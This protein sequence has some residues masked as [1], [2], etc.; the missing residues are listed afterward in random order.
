MAAPPA[1]PDVA[2]RAAGGPWEALKV[3]DFALLWTGSLGS[4][5]AMQ[6]QMLASGYLAYELTGSKFLL[7]LAGAAGALPILLFAPFGGVVA[8]RVDKR[9]LLLGTQSAL[10]AISF[11]TALLIA[12]GRIEFWH[13]ILGGFLS[14]IVFAF[15]M[16]ARQVLVSELV[17]PNVLMNAIALNTA[18]MNLTRIVGPAVAGLL[19]GVIGA[20]GIYFLGVGCY[21]IA[22]LCIVLVRY[23]PGLSA[24]IPRSVGGDLIIG[25]R[26]MLGHPVVRMLLLLGLIPAL[27]AQ[28][29]QVFLPVFAEDVWKVGTTGLGI[30]NAVP[31]VGGVAGAILVGALAAYPRKGNIQVAAGVITCVSIIAFALSPSFLLGLVM[32]LIS[33]VAGMTFMTINNTLLLT[34][35]A[36][37]MRGRVISISMTTF[38]LSPLGL[39]PTGMLAEAFGAPTAVAITGLLMALSCLAL[40]LTRREL[41]SV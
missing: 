29:Q 32:L 22:V 5:T 27:F 13:L 2:V 37:E 39:L 31:G 3:R 15:N 41:R 7:G 9:K 18:G 30:M 10:G 8:D 20:G 1:A 33:G 23:R 24:K 14:G 40:G 26:Y 21:A 19:L 38:G 16:P 35:A 28:A 4:F 11:M 17:G 12:T 6:M 25:G 34:V 36:P